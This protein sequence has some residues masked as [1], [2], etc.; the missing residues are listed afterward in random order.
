LVQWGLKVK[1]HQKDSV[2]LLDTLNKKRK[3]GEYRRERNKDNN[4][5]VSER[6]GGKKRVG[7][8]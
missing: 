3:K 4:A 8:D 6:A 5:L 2:L 7:E 1:S